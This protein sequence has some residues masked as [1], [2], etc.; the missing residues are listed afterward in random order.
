M[1]RAKH[2]V[3]SQRGINRDF[4]CLLITNFSDHNDIR[5]LTQHRAQRCRK[6]HPHIASDLHLIHSRHLI[7]NRILDSDN[8]TIGM[9]NAVQSRIKRGGFT[10]TRWS[11]HQE[12][13][14]WHRDNTLKSGLVI[15]E[16]PELWQA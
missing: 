9:V 2:H 8:F 15:A 3:P 14:V 16:E 10:R 12:H 1:Q 11:S 13:T 4:S 7:L 6:G 5:R